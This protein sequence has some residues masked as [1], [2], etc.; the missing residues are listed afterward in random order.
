MGHTSDGFNPTCGLRQGSVISPILFNI[1]L[2]DLSKDL[3]NS[4]IGCKITILLLITY[5]M[6]MI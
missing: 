1:Y 6:Q 4:K 2:N 5:A 3:K